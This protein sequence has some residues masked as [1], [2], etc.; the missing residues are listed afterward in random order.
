MYLYNPTSY[1]DLSSILCATRQSSLDQPLNHSEVKGTFNSHTATCNQMA[2]PAHN[3]ISTMETD[4]MP[5]KGAIRCAHE[6]DPTKYPACTKA[7]DKGENSATRWAH[8]DR[9]YP[10]SL[11]ASA[12][13]LRLRSSQHDKKNSITGQVG[14]YWHNYLAYAHLY[15]PCT[16]EREGSGRNQKKQWQTTCSGQNV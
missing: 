14:I 2:H 7:A 1:H 6:Y 3:V 5:R 16:C 12:C 13:P 11:E 10:H 4:G 15:S 9:R 8:I